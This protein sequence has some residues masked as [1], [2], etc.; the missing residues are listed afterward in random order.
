VRGT[1]GETEARRR[2][3]AIRRTATGDR[4]GEEGA[5]R[6]IVTRIARIAV[7]VRGALRMCGTRSRETSSSL[8][9]RG[10]VVVRFSFVDCFKLF[11]GANALAPGVTARRRV[12]SSNVVRRVVLQARPRVLRRRAFKRLDGRFRARELRQNRARD[13]DEKSAHVTSLHS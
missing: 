3:S 9:I 10:T 12:R 8:I 2:V 11:R 6:A 13:E 1:R 5:Q 4:V 7:L